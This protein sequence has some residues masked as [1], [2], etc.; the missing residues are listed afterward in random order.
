MKKLGLIIGEQKNPQ[1]PKN[2]H[3]E[4]QLYGVYLA[5]TLE[6]TSHY[7]LYIK[8]AKTYPRALL[9]NALSFV[10]GSTTARSKGKLFMWKIKQ[11]K[12]EALSTQK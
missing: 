12:D 11:L 10:K 1:R 7:S 2:L 4:F 8:L 3:T 6:D 9:E 5:E